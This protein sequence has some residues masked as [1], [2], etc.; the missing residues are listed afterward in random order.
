F[1]ANVDGY[2]AWPPVYESHVEMDGAWALYEAY[3]R[4]RMGDIDTALI[5]GSGKSSP[6]KPLE[7]FPLQT[8]PYVAAPLGFDPVSAAGLQARALL[9]SGKAT[10]RDFAEV[11]SRSRRDGLSN[12][13]AQV[14]KD[15]DVDTLLKEPYCASPLRKHDLPP[16]SDGAS[17]MLI[18]RGDKAR[19]LCDNP[20]WIRGIDHRMES[21]HLGLRDL[22]DSPST[23]IAAKSLGIDP[24]SL[25]VAELCVRYS[26]E[27]IVLRQAL[28]LGDNTRINPSGGPLCGHPVMSTGLTRV[29]ETARFIREGKAGR[30]LAH[31]ASGAALQHNLLCVL[32]G[33]S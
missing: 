13:Y 5:V 19:E 27:E 6:G 22:S 30:G 8:D 31:A 10:E 2:G 16:I 12:P 4:L 28:E 33:D 1:I 20:I 11:V 3:V 25:D 18:A 9:E 15:I 32:E 26:P 17:A 14:A 29:V 23:R 24:A 7:I 21:H